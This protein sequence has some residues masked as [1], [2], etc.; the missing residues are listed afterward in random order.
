[1][2]TK[3]ILASI[4]AVCMALS[5]MGTVVFADAAESDD[6][7][8]TVDTS[9][10]NTTDTEFVLTTAEQFA[11]FAAI[12]N[13]TA[14]G[15]AA[16]TF[17]HK[18]I[19]L[20]TDIDLDNRLWAP[21]GGRTSPTLSGQIE[22]TFDGQDHTISNL[23][24]QKGPDYEAVNMNIGLFGITRT[25]SFVAKNFTLENVDIY[26]SASVAAVLGRSVNCKAVIDNVDV[27]GNIKIEASQQNVGAI[28]AQTY[29]PVITDCNVIGNNG[30]YIKAG[31][32]QVG[33]ILG[34]SGE[35][36][37]SVFVQ[38]CSVENVTIS[39]LAYVSSIAAIVQYG[40]SIKNNTATNVR[41]EVLEGYENNEYYY[42][43]IIGSTGAGYINASGQSTLPVYISGNTTENVVVTLNGQTVDKPVKYG[44]HYA[45]TT[46][47]S[48]S[49]GDAYYE[50]LQVAFDALEDSSSMTIYEG[51]YVGDFAF[52][53]DNV[54][55]TSEGNVVIK[56]K[57]SL[58]QVGTKNFAAY[59]FEVNNITLAPESGVAV[60]IYGNGT[61][62]GCEFISNE[63]AIKFSYAFGD[64]G[65]IFNECMFDSKDVAIHFDEVKSSSFEVN[66]GTIKGSV[67]LGSGT[68]AAEFTG[69]VFEPATDSEEPPIIDFWGNAVLEDCVF[70]PSVKI[71]SKLA[72]KQVLVNDC[73]VSDGSDVFALVN[74]ESPGGIVVDEKTLNL[75]AK[76][77][78]TYCTTLQ[79][80]IDAAN[81]MTEPAEIDLLDNNVTIN[82]AYV[83]NNDITF[84][85]GTLTF[86]DYN[87]LDADVYD[88]V[89]EHYAVMTIGSNVTFDNVILSGN[90][91][92]ANEGIFVLETNGVMSLTNGSELN[93]IAPTATAVVYSD[94]T[95]KLVVN[96]SKINIDGDGNAVGGMLSLEIDAD[97]AEITVKDIADNAMENVNGAVDNSTITIDGAEYGIKSTGD[98]DVLAVTGSK[99]TVT[100]ATNEHDNAGIYLADRAM[101]ADS[102][103]IIDSI[104]YIEDGTVYNTLNFET[105]GG[106]TIG[107]VEKSQGSLVDLSEYKPEKAGYTFAG[108][109]SDEALIES[110]SSVTLDASKIVYA[111]WVEKVTHSGGSGV[112]NHTITFETNGGTAIAKIS[113]AKN[114][115]VDLSSY[116]PKKEGYSFEGW[117]TDK[118][119]TN[120]VTSVKLT[121]NTT[122]Y[123]KW[124]EIENE[125]G[126]DEPGTDEPG[127]DDPGT[128]EPG[129]DEP[130]T[131][132]GEKLFADVET[133]DWFY[134]N[135]KYAVENKL[136][137]GVGEDKFAPNDTLTRAML[138]T[139]LYRLES[140]P[141]VGDDAHN[142]PPFD[143]VDIDAYYAN[144]VIWAKQNGIVNG[145]SETEFL[146]S[147]NITREQIATILHRYA[148]YKGYDVSVGENTNI[149]SYTDA[150]SISEYAISSMQYVVGS[151]LIKG[152]SATTL[153]PL[154]NVTRA[155]LAAIL[156]RFIEA[157]SN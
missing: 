51:T 45:G 7:D 104:I 11:G 85:N 31:E 77:G 149:L 24:V 121:K 103:S 6:W 140:E 90:N 137:N 66:G 124:V 41:L 127:T 145:V 81:E 79:E 122:V 60:S 151:G 91:V 20:G 126:T 71:T 87:G 47:V 143:D 16:D 2:K 50:N 102:N 147:A 111:K 141:A 118:E 150:E 46:Y 135:V 38:N 63:N 116:V 152:K 27:I 157:N 59:G 138:V 55:V 74:T 107:T 35:S 34:W 134:E 76:I 33:G 96:D 89:G 106:S 130:G 155:E 154:D 8:G 25:G 39:A 22:C 125:P 15:I 14:E 136:M 23:K 37:N 94:G 10:Y 108:W 99:I 115:T 72:G 58:G 9:W 92:T 142:M 119:M 18:T 78:D 5:A 146:P 83:L 129:T 52:D 12:A 98:C 43:T 54:T 123:A 120:K 97:D 82:K 4:L 128:D 28:C 32:V 44:A 68:C 48:A 69:V 139:V 101:F 95:G 57:L 75:D 30:S 42:G 105:N 62:N 29:V 86:D 132:E 112:T 93:V 148:Q 133:S 61:F 17:A 117:Y 1:M 19:K 131:T 80:A 114:A 40:A 110:V 109:Y 3:K 84:K 153:N 100:N 65:V 73:S 53:K 36:S 70:T 67:Q 56:G 144:A 64:K 113:K 49:I 88:P 156:Q 13:G 26:G 21:I